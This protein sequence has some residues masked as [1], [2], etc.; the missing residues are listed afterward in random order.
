[1]NVMK[2]KL[3]MKN[4]EDEKEVATEI[5]AARARFAIGILSRVT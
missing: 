3:K 5:L 1:M 4:K 2:E